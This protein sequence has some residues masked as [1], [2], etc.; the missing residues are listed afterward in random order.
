MPIEVRPARRSDVPALAGVLARAFQDDPV[1]S[2]LQPDPATRAATL[3]GFFAAMARHHFLAGGGVEVAE[4][5]GRIGG[6]TLWNPPG[7]KVGSSVRE[8]AAVPAAIRAFRGRLGAARGVADQMKAAHPEEPHWYLAT[9]GSDPA[10]RGGGYGAALMHSRLGR[11]DA[12][13]APAYLESSNPDNIGYYERFGF[14]V[15]GEIAIA[16]GGPSLWPMWR[17]PQ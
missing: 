14:V 3:P 15:T 2:W 6:A 1:F 8:I 5:T 17:D 7:R 12:E 9:I 10:V 11:C 4:S 16:G 13:Y